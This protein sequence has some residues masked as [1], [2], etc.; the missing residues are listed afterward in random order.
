M[1]DLFFLYFNM[2]PND[3]KTK[4]KKKKKKKKRSKNFFYTDFIFVLQVSQLRRV[5]KKKKKNPKRI[6]FL[7][8]NI[9]QAS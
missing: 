2:E 4:I 7:S 5:F 8:F 9:S 3:N 1:A 6:M